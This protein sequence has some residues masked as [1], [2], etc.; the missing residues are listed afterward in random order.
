[1]TEVTKVEGKPSDNPTNENVIAARCALLDFWGDNAVSFA[2]QFV[3]S[4]FGLITMSALIHSVL[5]YLEDNNL[6]DYALIAFFI[7]SFLLYL[8]LSYVARYTYIRFTN[9]SSLASN[10]AFFSKGLYET[11]KLQELTAWIYPENPD[12]TKKLLNEA[13]ERCKE[14]LS[15]ETVPYTE[16]HKEGE[17][18]TSFKINYLLYYNLRIREQETSIMK[19][20]TK[21]R[22]LFGL[23]IILA[24]FF[25][26]IVTYY[27]LLLNVLN[28][29]W[30]FV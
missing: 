11:A 29:I 15:K 20:M 28:R 17:K 8:G 19:K 4:I 18:K 23:I 5:I 2:S 16:Y 1:M 3:A 26:W 7:F 22:R 9:Y 30:P 12:K 21:H 24:V 6:P 13:Y 27:P 25:L 14:Q 10:L